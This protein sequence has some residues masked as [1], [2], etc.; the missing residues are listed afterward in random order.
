MASIRL[1]NKHKIG[2]TLQYAKPQKGTHNAE[3]VDYQ[4]AGNAAGNGGNHAVNFADIGNFNLA[5]A[6]VVVKG[7]SHRSHIGVAHPVKEDKQQN[8]RPICPAGKIPERIVNGG[9][10]EFFDAFAKGAGI[11]YF[12]FFFVFGRFTGAENGK[13]ADNRAKR[14]YLIYVVPVHGGSHPNGTGTGKNQSET[15]AQ[16]KDSNAGA[17]FLAVEAF[18]AVSIEDDVLR[19]GSHR[20]QNREKSHSK[21]CCRRFNGRHAENG[22]QQDYLDK[23]CPAAAA[24]QTTEQRQ[25]NA[26]DYRRPGPF[27]A[28]RRFDQRKQADGRVG[29]SR[30]LKPEVQRAEN[31]Q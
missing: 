10:Q 21:R 14:H 12:G 6:H 29:Y 5:E 1:G 19:S 13:H 30:V 3:T 8:Q 7:I 26:V 31:Q 9:K 17:L 15:I 2:N 20:N 16:N 27:E 28:V 11:A 25:P 18:N 4:T 23:K 24:S 22:K